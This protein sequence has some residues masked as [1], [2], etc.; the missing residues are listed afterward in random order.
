MGAV[1]VDEP[2]RRIERLDPDAGTPAARVI[3][4]LAGLLRACLDEGASIGFL[5]PFRQAE[6]E[7]FWRAQLTGRSTWLAWS[8]EALDGCVQLEPSHYPNGRHRA[9]VVKLLVAPRARRRGVARTLMGE[10]EAFALGRGIT[11]LMLDTETD[12]PA[13]QLYRALGWQPFGVVEAHSARP[14]GVLAATT[15]YSRHLGRQ[16][17]PGPRTDP[18]ATWPG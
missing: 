4:E 14:D 15:F 13:E 18:P 3:P 8:G 16:H 17:R 10:L 9:E 11:L 6:A 1:P 2:C 12:S 7:A 5:H